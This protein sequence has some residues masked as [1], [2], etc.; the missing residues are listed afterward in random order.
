MSS[1]VEKKAYGL[2]GMSGQPK[3]FNEYNCLQ[4]AR[5]YPNGKRVDSSNYDPQPLWNVGCQLVALNYQT[6]GRNMWLNEGRFFLNGRCGYVI[7]PEG[8][9][10]PSFDPFN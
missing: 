5:V 2:A 10:Q 6:A 4:I 9:R 8:Q 3:E 7:K 1:F